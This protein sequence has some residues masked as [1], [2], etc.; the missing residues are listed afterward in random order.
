MCEKTSV[1]GPEVVEK[2]GREKNKEIM[3]K[4]FPNLMKSI[5]Q[6]FKNLNKIKQKKQ[7]YIKGYN[8]IAEIQK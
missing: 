2:R 8:Q 3:V 5:N 6:R 4:V 1:W 7:N